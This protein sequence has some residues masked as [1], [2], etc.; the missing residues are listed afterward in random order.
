MKTTNKIK[1]KQTKTFN[2]TDVSNTSRD[3]ADSNVWVW[4]VVMEFC[5]TICSVGCTSVHSIE[6]PCSNGELCADAE[7]S[8][9]IESFELEAL[10]LIDSSDELDF[11]LSIFSLSSSLKI[12]Q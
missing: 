9:N 5:S 10:C 11:K 7:L 4:V 12:Q 2:H 8:D 1:K 6:P 3:L